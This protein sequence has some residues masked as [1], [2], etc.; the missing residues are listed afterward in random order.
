MNTPRTDAVFKDCPEGGDVVMMV[1]DLSRQLER[2]LTAEQEKVKRL[3]EALA[4][5]L[6]YGITEQ[7]LDD[8]HL[9]DKNA[10]IHV[11]ADARAI[12][13]ATK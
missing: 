11:V 10:P 7:D 4:L 5:A 3:R 1:L 9:L 2:E 6:R 12:L 8:A 13:E